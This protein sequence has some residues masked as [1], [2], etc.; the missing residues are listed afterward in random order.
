MRETASCRRSWNLRSRI[1]ASLRALRKARISSS[2]DTG[3]S[4]AS[5]ET[6][7]GSADMISTARRD[8]GTVRAVVSS[9]FRTCAT[10]RPTSRSPR[11]NESNS[12]WRRAVSSANSASGAKYAP[13]VFSAASSRSSSSPT[14]RRSRGLLGSVDTV[15]S[16]RANRPS[17]RAQRRLLVCAYQRT[18]IR[19][20]IYLLV[21]SGLM[22]E[23]R[24]E[25]TRPLAEHFVKLYLEKGRSTR[26]NARLR[27]EILPRPLH[28]R[29]LGRI[30]SVRV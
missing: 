23:S 9:E 16:V 22:A 21:R 27:G 8:S 3:N 20:A 10:L 6:D 7:F 17:R 15:F 18:I 28:R 1:P 14:S 5:R 29:V 25:C 12:A 2:R 26:S 4:G 13:Y 11:V 30:R 19:S 24:A